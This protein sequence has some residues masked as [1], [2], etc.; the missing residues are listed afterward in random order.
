MNNKPAEA[1]FKEYARLTQEENKT[2]C[3]WLRHILL[4]VS[5]LLGILISLGSNTQGC[6]YVRLCFS[7]ANILFALATAGLLAVLY[8]YS[9][10]SARDIR[11]AYRNEL[12]SAIAE[13]RSMRPA[14]TNVSKA[15]FFLEKASYICIGAAL[16]LLAVY[17]LMSTFN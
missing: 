2:I 9:A 14:G 8:T 7:L 10:K 4:V 3:A 6:L 1:D 11:E 16:I 17:S 13:G 15:V 12:E 5:T